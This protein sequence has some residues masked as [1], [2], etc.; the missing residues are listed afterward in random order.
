MRSAQSRRPRTRA[1]TT[2]PPRLLERALECGLFVLLIGARLPVGIDPDA[3]GVAIFEKFLRARGPRCAS[4]ASTA[5]ALG[6]TTLRF[7]TLLGRTKPASRA[8]ELRSS[9]PQLLVDVVDVDSTAPAALQVR[10]R[11]PGRKNRREQRQDD[12]TEQ[13]AAGPVDQAV[14]TGSRT[15]TPAAP[16]ARKMPSPPSERAVVRRTRP[17]R[18]EAPCHERDERR[19]IRPLRHGP[20]VDS[21]SASGSR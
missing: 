7:S 2:A 16:T 11:H 17:S 9:A 18:S 21:C 20:L 3:V 19:D 10:P 12:P 4:S 8:D 6:R 13:V 5:A 14:E 15:P 1:D